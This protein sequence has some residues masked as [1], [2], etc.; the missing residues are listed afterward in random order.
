MS[1]ITYRKYVPNPADEV[2]LEDLVDQL[3]EFLLE[4]GFYSQFYPNARQ[5][6]SLDNLLRALARILAEQ[7]QVPEEWREE[8]R[9]FAEEEGEVELSEEVEDFLQQVLNRLLEEG[10]LRAEEPAGGEPEPGEGTVDEV[11]G[12]VR[13]ELTDKGV[14]LLGYKTLRELLGSMGRSRFG[15]HSTRHL[16]TGVEA[17]SQSRPYEFG[18]TL[19]LDVTETLLNT[20]RREGLGL[21]LKPDYQDLM[22]YQSEYQSSCATV[23]LLDCSHSMILYGEDRF[24]PAKKVALALAHLIRTQYPSDTLDLVLFHDSAERIP[25][26]KLP[27][28]KVGPY[29]TNTREGLRLARNILMNQRKEM[30]QIVM[31]TD[32]KPSAITLEDGRIYK[33]PFG[34]DPL[35][36]EKTYQEVAH[37]RRSNI[38]I[39]T[40]MLARDYSLVEFVKKVSQICRGKA[41]FTTTLNLASYILMDFM[42]RKTRTVH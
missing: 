20:L 8:L 37:C 42:N 39:N 19:N 9:R 28:V 24:T 31:I 29:H 4:S 14:D 35:V 16:S 15:R 30:R 10:Y 26:A 12:S 6:A 33:N 11:R 22:V 23:L 34:L 36:L 3:K 1:R 41:Y 38:L 2:D 21:P 5:E 18:D 32:G 17:D 27:S 7:E 13:F 40:F 25:L